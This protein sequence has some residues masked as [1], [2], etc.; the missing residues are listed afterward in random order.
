MSKGTLP[1]EAG[2]LIHQL[3]KLSLTAVYFQ[4]SLPYDVVSEGEMKK[5]RNR[6]RREGKK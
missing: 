1:P 4:I 5:K 2:F 3:R 6:G